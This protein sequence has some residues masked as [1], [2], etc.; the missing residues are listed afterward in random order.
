LDIVSIGKHNPLLAD[1]RKAIQRDTLTSS[2]LLP[3]EGPKLVQEAH[4]SNMAIEALLLREGILPGDFPPASVTYRL[5]PGTFKEIQDTTRSQGVMALVRPREWTL[6]DV[7]ARLRA[8]VAVLAGLQDP[9]NVGTILRIVE[10][11]GGAGCIGLSGTAA[12]HNAKV[13]RASAGSVFRLP[14]VWNVNLEAVS[15]AL[16]TRKIPLIG[17]S[18]YARDSITSWDWTRPTAVF[19]GNE[20][21]GL[22]AEQASA[23]SAMLQI[24]HEPETESLN[25]AIAAAVI[26]YEAARSKNVR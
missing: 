24:P 25:S 8:P 23:C 5:D 2:G 10:S 9:G 18:P 13:V 3:I 12:V 19:I 21:A 20:G 11:F 17:T 16:K 15:D 14:H 22:S 7:L 4:A 1:I 26:F 6:S